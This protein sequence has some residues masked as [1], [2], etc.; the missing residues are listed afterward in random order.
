MSGDDIHL[1]RVLSDESHDVH[2]FHIDTDTISYNTRESIKN[3]AKSVLY[4]KNDVIVHVRVDCDGR[5]LITK[6]EKG[7][8]NIA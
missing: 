8:E 3:I 6:M 2:E 4:T 1:S 7:G 5:F